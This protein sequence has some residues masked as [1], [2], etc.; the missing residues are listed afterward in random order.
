MKD[1]IN[2]VIK[3]NIFTPENVSRLK[4]FGIVELLYIPVSIVY[5][6]SSSFIFQHS[7]FFNHDLRVALDSREICQLLIH[8]LEYLIFAGIFAFGLKLKQEN[9]LTI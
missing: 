2:D 8:G 5:Y 4:R 6:Y 7:A 1:L 9:D 3:G